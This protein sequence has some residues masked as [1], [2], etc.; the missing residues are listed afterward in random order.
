MISKCTTA[1][2]LC[3]YAIGKDTMQHIK[4]PSVGQKYTIKLSNEFKTKKAYLI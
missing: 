4:L 2:C 3:F 1:P